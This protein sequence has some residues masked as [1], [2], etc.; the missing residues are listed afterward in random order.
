MKP[1]IA[2]I[3]HKLRG[4]KKKNHDF[5]IWYPNYPFCDYEIAQIL[6]NVKLKA[7]SILKVLKLISRE[8][9]E[10]EIFELSQS[11]F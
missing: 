2:S 5:T 1:E 10:K 3:F 6:K 8:I 4:K 7:F 11:V 9:Y